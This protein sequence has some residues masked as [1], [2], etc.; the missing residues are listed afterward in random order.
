MASVIFHAWNQVRASG[1]VKLFR[2]HRPDYKDGMQLRDFIY[3]KDV[4][5]V[6]YFLMKRGEQPGIFNL[7]TGRARTFY[8]LASAVFK[9]LDIPEKIEFID[10]PVDIR[11][12]YQY[13]TEAEMGKLRNTGYD[14]PFY[15]L[16]EGVEEYVK[17]FLITGRHF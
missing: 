3:V 15:T 6:L 5:D 16:E 12:K 2:S 17:E 8:D 4:V 7:G 11:D 10:T 14:D 9:S 1:K 13:F